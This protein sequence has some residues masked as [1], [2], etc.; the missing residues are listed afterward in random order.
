MQPVEKMTLGRYERSGF[1]IRTVGDTNF[2]KWNATIPQ[3]IDPGLEDRVIEFRKPS[4]S[5]FFQNNEIYHKEIDCLA[6]K[7][8]NNATMVAIDEVEE[9]KWLYIWLVFPNGTILDNH[10]L[11]SD[12]GIVQM[13]GHG[14]VIS[15]EEIDLEEDFIGMGLYW[16]IAKKG[17]RRI[18]HRAGQ[19]KMSSV[20]KSKKK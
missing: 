1:H 4:V 18:A 9:R 13:E 16:R 20:F 2:E 19:S 17:G 3:N 10:I 7:N 11:S 5:S 12:D 15:K 14:L 8:E 6:T